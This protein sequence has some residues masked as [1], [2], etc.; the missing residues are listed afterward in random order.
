MNN[1]SYKNDKNDKNNVNSIDAGVDV[2]ID[3]FYFS[4]QKLNNPKMLQ[5]LQNR[6][7]SGT[8]N[9]FDIEY[10]LDLLDLFSK[11]LE[12]K[13]HD[14]QFCSADE[15]IVFIQFLK[16]ENLL[17][18][19]D[20]EIGGLE[21]FDI[22]KIFGD[23]DFYQGIA[24]LGVLSH[25]T[26]TNATGLS[27]LALIEGVVTGNVNILRVNSKDGDVVVRLIG[28][29]LKLD[30]QYKGML[31][32]KL[33]CIDVDSRNQNL[34]KQIFFMSDAVSMWGGDVAVNSVRELLPPQ[35]KFI[36]WGHKIS[37]VYVD[38]DSFDNEDAM[39][40]IAYECVNGEQSACSSPQVIY[41]NTND[42]GQVKQYAKKFQS[43]FSQE[44][45]RMKFDRPGNSELSELSNV[46][47]VH[48]LE[49]CLGATIGDNAV[50]LEGE[51]KDYRI[52]VENEM[53]LKASPLFRTVW[54]RPL[55]LEHLPAVL[56][57]FRDYLQSAGV[58]SSNA[59][60]VIDRLIAA[61]VTRITVPGKMTDSFSGEA[62]DGKLALNQFIRH[63]S[64]RYPLKNVG[65]FNDFFKTISFE[66][67]NASEKILSKDQFKKN[68][69]S[70]GEVFFKSGG[71]SGVPAVSAFTYRDYEREMQYAAD[72]IIAAG[73]SVEEDSAINLFFGGGLYGGMI[74]FFT[75]LEKIKAK[76]YPM[77]AHDDLQMVASTIIQFKINTLFGMPSYIIKLLK[78]YEKELLAYGGI[79][80]I[81]F[82]G[83][84]FNK[85]QKKYLKEI[86]KID[87]LRS[88]SYGSVDAGPLGYSCEYC[89]DGVHHL[90]HRLH[91]FKMIPLLDEN[92][93]GLCK[94]IITTK[95]RLG[96]QIVN[97][98]IG[99][100][101]EA[102]VGPCQ[103]G[104]VSPRFRLLGRTGD[105]FRAGGTFFNYM[106]I[107]RILSDCNYKDVLQIVIEGNTSGDILK[108]ILLKQTVVKL[109]AKKNKS[110]N[111]I[112]LDLKMILLNEYADLSV[113]VEDEKILGLDIV[114][115]ESEQCFVSSASSGKILRVVDK[116]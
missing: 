17:K 37:F 77:G 91:D 13:S 11:Q 50:L 43:Y 100:V 48:D 87:F 4:E 70:K 79:K 38:F 92:N 18:K 46:A 78:N 113:A 10:V 21:Y 25:V 36:V 59:I 72:G 67:T 58:V 84:H 97:Y 53:N 86:F 73:F 109:F 81:F 95:S 5:E 28:E 63:I 74:S 98:D 45:K 90:H 27:F 106:K 99:D 94:L 62:H 114:L 19:I 12:T 24:P 108:L 8:T 75:I 20:R 3:S 112:I 52:L 107:E 42:F 116:R 82:G 60:Q 71:S 93:S 65:A 33:F 88:A 85:D 54:I 83:E 16:R 49:S 29:L 115:L 55:P 103:C 80:K 102:I 1:K 96:D 9:R 105:I 23:K 110:M 30:C 101:G 51:S 64:V 26:P 69:K 7:I 68:D 2:G 66:N 35:K 89:N 47:I 44:S 34:L 61:G 32:N 31:K 104:R 40:N 57:D 76:Q 39:K 6:V 22:R 41:L 15:M 56:F 111:E 14:Y